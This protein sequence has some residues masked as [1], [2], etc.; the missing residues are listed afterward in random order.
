MAAKTTTVRVS[1]REE[2]K[3]RYR[4]KKNIE[5]KWLDQ[6]FEKIILPEKAEAVPNVQAKSFESD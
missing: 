3:A 1:L 5:T 2:A 4:D 6:L